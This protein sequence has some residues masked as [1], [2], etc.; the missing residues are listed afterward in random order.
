[1]DYEIKI[2]DTKIFSSDEVKIKRVLVMS[3]SI[4]TD[5]QDRSTK[6]FCRVEVSFVINHATRKLCDDLLSWSFENRS[7]IYRD[8]SICICAG[9][10]SGSYNTIRNIEIPRMFCEDCFEDYSDDRKDTGLF[11]IKMI[12]RGGNLYNII[13]RSC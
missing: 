8:V 9:D 7:N 2:G 6:V 10:Y 4:D 12:Q 3:D 5:L 1:M 11:T 13:I